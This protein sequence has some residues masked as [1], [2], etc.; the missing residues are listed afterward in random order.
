MPVISLPAIAGRRAKA[1][2][3]CSTAPDEMPIG[4]PSTRAQS[5]AVA[6]ALP[7]AGGHQFVDQVQIQHGGTETGA[8][9]RL[10][11]VRPRLVAGQHGAFRRLHPHHQQA[12]PPRLQR[13]RD[14]GQRTASAD[15]GHHRI[16]RA[17]GVGPDLLRRGGRMD[18]RIG[19]IVELPRHPGAR[20]R[21]HDR[22]RLGDR[23]RPCRRGTPSAPIP[24]PAAASSADAPP[25]RLPASPRSAGSRGQRRRRPVRSRY[26]RWSAPP[27]R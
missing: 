20:C 23:P 12:R 17:G 14:A 1:S 21:R 9:A 7:L 4:M 18:V 19:R 27:K 10:D 2:I 5:R 13:P 11:T 26:C 22:L 6:I 3:A 24:P 8:D 16:D 25:T 15:P